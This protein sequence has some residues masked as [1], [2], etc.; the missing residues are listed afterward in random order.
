MGVGRLGWTLFWLVQ[1][2]LCFT[3]HCVAF[4]IL[5][6]RFVMVWEA[7]IF[8]IIRICVS[9]R[10]FWLSMLSEFFYASSVISQVLS[11]R[12]SCA[13]SETLV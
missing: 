1:R 7:T 12:S 6:S 5:Q 3:H 9:L 10:L 13:A 11:V 2:G 4:G 8:I